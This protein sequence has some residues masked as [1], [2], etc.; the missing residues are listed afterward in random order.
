[1]YL[2]VIKPLPADPPAIFARRWITREALHLPVKLRMAFNPDYPWLAADAVRWLEDRLRPEM[3][4][5]EWGAGRSTVFMARRVAQ[6]ASVE[7]KKKWRRRVFA[8]LEEQG[9]RNVELRFC[10]P[11]GGT[12]TGLAGEPPVKSGF[13]PYA[14]AIL[15]FPRGYFDLILIDGRS[16]VACAHHAVPR[17]KPGGALVLD[18][19]ERTKY[20][21]IYRAL[22]LWPKLVFANGVWRTTV[23]IKPNETP[24]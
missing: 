6:V 24:E 13:G 10:P 9:I 8:R 12:A 16:R 3:R 20:H 19:S 17:L 22:A 11:D 15:D 21:P 14:R 18:N 23:F 7:H 2:P 1:M 5:F 4:T